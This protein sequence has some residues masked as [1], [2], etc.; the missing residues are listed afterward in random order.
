MLTL[1]DE[2]EGGGGEQTL[3]REQSNRGEGIPRRIP[4]AKVGFAAGKAKCKAEFIAEK[5]EM[6]RNRNR[7]IEVFDFLNREM[8]KEGW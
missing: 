1:R 8:Q 4:P 5:A 3:K 2:E 7:K 6:R